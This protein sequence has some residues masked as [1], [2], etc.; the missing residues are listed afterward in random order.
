M[1]KYIFIIL[2]AL[3]SIAPL[4]AQYSPCYEAAFAEGQKLY[5]AGKYSQAKKYFNEAKD[6]PDSNTV[7]ADEWIRKCKAKMEEIKADPSALNKKVRIDKGETSIDVTIGEVSFRM[8]KVEG[9]TYWMGAQSENSSER[10]YDPY[11]EEDEG[12]VHEVT[13]S[14][15]YIGETEVTQ[16]LWMA[17]MSDRL[18]FVEDDECPIENVSWSLCREFV[19]KLSKATGLKFRMPTEAEWEFAARGGING[20]RYLFSGSGVLDSVGWYWQNSG[21]V[22]LPG[23]DNSWRYQDVDNNKCQPHKVKTK[24]P[25]SLGIFDMSGNVMEWCSDKYGKYKD[26]KQ[27]NPKGYA[28]KTVWHV[29]R[30]GSWRGFK[31]DCRVSNRNQESGSYYELAL[32]CGLRLA[33]TE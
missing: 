9:G 17:F 11:A 28:G 7:A 30:G 15:F 33:L 24:M 23:T 32:N 14:D 21:D 19:Q 31:K 13:V 16:A 3:L 4:L 10:N 22:F 1:K 18:S 29:T 8:L 12:P 26:N 5:K 25:N 20:D 6:C 2:T 27:T